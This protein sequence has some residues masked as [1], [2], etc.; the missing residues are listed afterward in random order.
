MGLPVWKGVPVAVLSEEHVG[1][2]VRTGVQDSDWLTVEEAV[3]VINGNELADSVDVG[4]R[5]PTALPVDERVLEVLGMGVR[6]AEALLV[7]ERV[8]DALCVGVSVGV[9]DGDARSCHASV[10]WPWPPAWP[11]PGT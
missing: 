9:G 10:T 4:V 1:E 5:V 6:V 7:A 11:A 2:L 8:S 3:A